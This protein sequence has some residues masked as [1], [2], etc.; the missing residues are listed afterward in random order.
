MG[1]FTKACNE[2][3]FCCCLQ[4]QFNE[5]SRSMPKALSSPTRSN[6]NAPR[7]SDSNSSIDGHNNGV[8][9]NV[10]VLG[11]QDLENVESANGDSTIDGNSDG[12]GHNNGVNVNVNVLGVQKIKNTES[13]NVKADR[14]DAL[15][16]VV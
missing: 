12:D 9:V 11:I 13:A 10:N 5:S 16:G 3:D 8:N 15:P 1:C 7:G 14:E 2:S 6:G 4:R